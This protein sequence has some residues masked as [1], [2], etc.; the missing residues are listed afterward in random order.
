[1]G[2]GSYEAALH[3]LS[4]GVPVITLPTPI[5]AG[6]LTLALYGVMGL[7][8]DDAFA[9]PA[10]ASFS[11]TATSTATSPIVSTINE[12]VTLALQLTHQPQLRSHYCSLILQQRYKLFQN[13]SDRIFQDWHSFM[14][15][16][17]INSSKTAVL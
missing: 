17:L 3:A 1:V 5:L 15:S 13:R 7:Q 14:T 12:Y 10:S 2:G 9:A 4:M 11:A 8:R 6:R 16:A